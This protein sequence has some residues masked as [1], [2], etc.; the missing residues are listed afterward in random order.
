MS[1][2]A[3]GALLMMGGMAS[4]TI[5]DACLKLLLE[6]LPLFQTLFLR[7]IGTVVAFACLLPFWG[8]FRMDLH[9]R[10]WL[11]IGLDKL[12]AKAQLIGGKVP[13]AV[14]LIPMPPAAAAIFQA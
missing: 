10:D 2:N 9:R 14:S 7:G 13:A 3:R 5:N 6:D 4:F 11:L 1:D 12:I 8:G